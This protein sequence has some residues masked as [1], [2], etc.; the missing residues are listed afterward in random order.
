VPSTFRRQHTYRSIVHPPHLPSVSWALSLASSSHLI[1]P[2]VS[3]SNTTP[4]HAHQDHP[5]IQAH[6]SRPPSSNRDTASQVKELPPTPAPSRQGLSSPPT[7]AQPVHSR[8]VFDPPSKRT[9]PHLHPPPPPSG[10]G[11]R[12][13]FTSVP[14]FGSVSHTLSSSA[15]PPPTRSWSIFGSGRVI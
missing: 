3:F 15:L 12:L 2:H 9:H 6:R 11:P 14:K 7:S 8:A 10:Q 1:S 4:P 5:P 13:R